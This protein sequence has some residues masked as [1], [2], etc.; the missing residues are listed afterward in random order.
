MMVL[1]VVCA[2]LIMT[3]AIAVILWLV[4]G[5]FVGFIFDGGCPLFG[6]VV[7]LVHYHMSRFVQF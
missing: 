4:S 7:A 2:W 1:C 6:A 5:G 3:L